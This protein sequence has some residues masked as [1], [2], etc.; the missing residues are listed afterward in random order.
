MTTPGQKPQVHF[1]VA[2]AENGAIGQDGDMPW[3]RSLP[4]DLRH[5]R[6]LTMGHSVIMGR[7]TYDTLPSGGLPGRKMVVLSRRGL[8]E[9]NEGVTVAHSAA[10]ALE[11]LAGEEV[12]FVIGGAQV[13]AEMLSCADCLHIT[14]VHHEWPQADTYFP[15]LDLDQWKCVETVSRQADE[16]NPY[17]LSF[18]RW[19]RS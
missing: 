2:M 10:E 5:F 19:E 15:P 14:L 12:V 8:S 7:K 17:P 9:P 11:T 18:T 1:V 3:K 4:A 13:Y 16:K 6:D